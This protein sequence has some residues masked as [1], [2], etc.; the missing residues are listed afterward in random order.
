MAGFNIQFRYQAGGDDQFVRS[1]GQE[2]IQYL[3]SINGKGYDVIIPWLARGQEPL[4]G[5]YHK[6]S[7]A[8]IDSCLQQ[9]NCQIIRALENLQVRRVSEAEIL[10]VTGDLACFKNINRPTDL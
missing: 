6:R 3:C 9:K 2:L 8:V 5:I 4:F 1:P 7:L 10:A